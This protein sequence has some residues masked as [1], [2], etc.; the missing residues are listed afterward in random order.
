MSTHPTNLN[1]Q[2]FAI[3]DILYSDWGHG[4]TNVTFVQVERLTPQMAV[5]RWLDQRVV[6]TTSWASELVEPVPDSC[7]G[8]PFRRKIHQVGEEACVELN[9]FRAAFRWNGQPRHQSHWH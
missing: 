8:E 4:Q 3:G 7:Y 6:G 9:S 5:L 2:P 1:P